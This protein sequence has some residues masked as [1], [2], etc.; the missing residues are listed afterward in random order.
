MFCYPHRL[1]NVLKT[2]F[3][4]SQSKKKQTS[5]EEEHRDSSS[6]TTS[7][8]TT[9]LILNEENNDCSSSS[10]D[11]DYEKNQPTLPIKNKK[12]Y[13]NKSITIKLINNPRQLKLNDLHP[14]AQQVI[15]TI[16]KCKN[17]V[18]FV[19]KVRQSLIY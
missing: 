5:E 3:F 7:S 18:R 17:L 2:S 12:Y 4:Q 16:S 1:N 9:D 13:K 10:T 6:T 11:E 8:N 15:K 14:A 19:K